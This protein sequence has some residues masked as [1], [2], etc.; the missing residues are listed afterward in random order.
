M[1]ALQ[2]ILALPL[3]LALQLI[4]ALPLMLVHLLLGL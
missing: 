4:L 1:L 3:M 2:L